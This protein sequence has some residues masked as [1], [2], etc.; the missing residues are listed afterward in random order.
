MGNLRS[1]EHFQLRLVKKLRDYEIITYLFLGKA[2]EGRKYDKTLDFFATEKAA[3]QQ[4][5]N[6]CQRSDERKGLLPGQF[7]GVVLTQF[8]SKSGSF[9]VH[10]TLPNMQSADKPRKPGT[11][12]WLYYIEPENC[13]VLKVNTTEDGKH[14]IGEEI[15]N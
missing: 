8:E 6:F 1:N 2:K 13:R 7:R 10:H 11:T 5:R 3:L 15:V 12:R 14:F 9:I 4:V